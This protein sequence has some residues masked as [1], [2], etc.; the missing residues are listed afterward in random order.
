MEDAVL[1]LFWLLLKE[2]TPA[3][4]VGSSLLICFLGKGGVV[5]GLEWLF[6][7]GDGCPGD[8]SVSIIYLIYALF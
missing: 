1:V 3:R 7:L 4:M 5:V 2:N 8:S 6:G